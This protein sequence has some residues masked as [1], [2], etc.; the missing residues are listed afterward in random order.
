[1]NSLHTH[2]QKNCITNNIIHPY[3]QAYMY[4]H[5]CV[6]TI[7]TRA[8][9][10]VSVV[11]IRMYRFF[12]YSLDLSADPYPCKWLFILTGSFSCN[13]KPLIATIP[14]GVIHKIERQLLILF[15]CGWLIKCCCCIAIHWIHTESNI[16][17]FI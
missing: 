12:I 17:I 14:A 11:V 4:L 13:Y 9:C 6:Y 1:M 10:C 5:E 3:Q 8:Q 15:L 2:L 7:H 16:I